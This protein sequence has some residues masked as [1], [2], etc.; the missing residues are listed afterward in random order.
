MKNLLKPNFWTE[1]VE[2]IVIIFAMVFVHFTLYFAGIYWSD[3]NVS[4]FQSELIGAFLTFFALFVI[5]LVKV[6]RVIV[7]AF[8]GEHKK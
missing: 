6:A 7:L 8:E 1:L 5:A 3:P 4:V 2:F